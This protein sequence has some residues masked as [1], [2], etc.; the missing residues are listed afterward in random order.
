[1]T[2]TEWHNWQDF[3]HGADRAMDHEQ[4]LRPSRSHPEVRPA[5]RTGSALG[6]LGGTQVGTSVSEH[7]IDVV[8]QDGRA[9]YTARGNVS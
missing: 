2:M 3:A 4:L 6:R 7:S 9:A 8:G 5:G 1:M